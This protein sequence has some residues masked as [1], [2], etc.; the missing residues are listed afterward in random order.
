MKAHPL[1]TQ[2]AACSPIFT[3]PHRF[4]DAFNGS[5]SSPLAARGFSSLLREN[6][7]TQLLCLTEDRLYFL[8]SKRYLHARE[9]ET[10]DPALIASTL[11]ETGILSHAATLDGL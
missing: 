2:F 6:G 10:L 11:K 7:I 9:A 4:R 1:E 8:Y 5:W 3:W